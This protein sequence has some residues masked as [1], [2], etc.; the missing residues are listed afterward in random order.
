MSPKH[1]RRNVTSLCRA[2]GVS[3]PALDRLVQEIVEATLNGQDVSIPG[4]GVFH[5]QRV[6]ERVR[7][8]PYRGQKEGRVVVLR[9]T[10]RVR[11]RQSPAFRRRLRNRAAGRA[12][13]TQG[14]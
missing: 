1:E 14:P 10:F 13:G 3:R 12:N 7:T 2:A 8:V 4:F 5:A 11:F 9:E 6:P